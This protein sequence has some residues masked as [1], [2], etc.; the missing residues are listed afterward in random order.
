MIVSTNTLVLFVL[1]MNSWNHV[2][3]CCIPKIMTLIYDFNE[4]TNT[5][6]YK[7][8]ISHTLFPKGLMFLWCVRDGWRQGQTAILTQ[9]L[10]LTIARCVIFKNPLSTPS[11]SWLGLLNRG[12]LRATALSLQVGP[13]SELP[14]INWHNGRRHLPI[15]FHN[16][17]LLPLLLPLIYP[18]ASL[19]DGS[20]KSQY[21]TQTNDYY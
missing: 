20:V 4:R 19:I 5:L 15:S 14:G 7:N 11:T 9:L 13:H 18:G 21:I 12:S 17:H 10:L 16:A 3:K 6:L 1:D 8:Y 2:Y